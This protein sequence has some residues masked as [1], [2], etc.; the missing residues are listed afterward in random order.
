MKIILETLHHQINSIPKKDARSKIVPLELVAALLCSVQKDSGRRSI[1]NIR[2]QVIALTGKKISRSSFWERLATLRLKNFLFSLLGQL[3][4][5]IAEVCSVGP[6]L[7]KKLGV[8]GIFIL[9]SS[10][11]S[12]PK[13][14]SK[15]FPAPRNNVVPAA[16][17][18]HALFDLLGGGLTWFDLTEATTH[19]RKR[20]PPLELLPAKALLIFDLGYWDYL[21]LQELI[22]SGFYFLSRVKTNAKIQIKE[23]ISGT[24]KKYVGKNL[25]SC[26]FPAQA[27][28]VVDVMGMFQKSGKELFTC[29][30]VGFW[31][32]VEQ[33]YHWYATNLA[34]VA[35]AIY[36]LYR[37]RWQCELIFKACKSSMNF[38][39]ITTS[40]S[41]I[42]VNLVL[43]GILHC[44]LASVLGGHLASKLQ[45][46]KQMS[47]SVQ[48]CAIIF[49][50]SSGDLFRF[51]LDISC[52]KLLREKLKLLK[53]ELFDPNFRSR[54]SSLAQAYEALV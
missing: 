33:H 54:K 16:I 6:E 49:V 41:K 47:M 34:I 45:L 50:Q 31:N 26:R 35:R 28:N 20:F 48:R 27:R 43:L 30:I 18:W 12:L 46:E 10:S 15:E 52:L 19:D 5:N 22:K 14:A 3:S 11:V 24:S 8:S 38:S 36:P 13:D 25:M 17:K 32:P 53:S 29:R 1:S 2:R 7:L 42:I 9:D 44:L 37:L 4:A 40:D 21:L 51:I 23:V 39:S